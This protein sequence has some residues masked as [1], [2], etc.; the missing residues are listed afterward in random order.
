MTN[1]KLKQ[2]LADIEAMQHDHKSID[3]FEI[4]FNLALKKVELL[5]KLKYID[6]PNTFYTD[7]FIN[8]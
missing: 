1:D 7:N 3:D 4:G 5:I 8:L 2:L 6:K